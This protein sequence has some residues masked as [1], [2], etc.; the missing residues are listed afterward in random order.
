[1]AKRSLSTSELK[2]HCSRVVDE[3]SKRREPVV[4]TKRGKP[5]A[6]LVPW[7][8][9]PTDLFGFA[10]GSITVHGDLLAPVDVDWEAAG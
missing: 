10:R 4:I 9:E 7:E 3:V 8:E 6:R 2:A 1:M 5:V